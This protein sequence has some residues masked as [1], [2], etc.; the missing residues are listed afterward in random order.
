[1]ETDSSAD[2]TDPAESVSASPQPSRRKSVIIAGV[3]IVAIA[4][5]VG[6]F[7]SSRTV[8]PGKTSPS[9]S[10]STRMKTGDPEKVADEGATLPRITDPPTNTHVML[11]LPKGTPE[12]TFAVTFEPYGL[13]PS[14]G[15]VIRVNNARATD[16]A[17]EAQ[18]L[19]KRLTGVNLVVT[20]GSDVAAVSM[21]GG[22]YS[23]VVN[24]VED[25]DAYSFALTKAEEAR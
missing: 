18:N 14:G 19:A 11:S 9:A 3:A 22:T 8:T 21:R 17:T 4:L 10:S 12:M 13:A 1:V 6:S 24:T 23:G 25:Q 7:I 2:S 5:V 16:S 15:I 20:P